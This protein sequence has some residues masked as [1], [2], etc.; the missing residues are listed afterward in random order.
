MITSTLTFD[1]AQFFP[2]LNHCLLSA[3]LGKAGFD[4]KVVSFF[5]NYLVDREMS[6]FWNNFSF[7]LYNVNVGVGQGSA[8]SSIL[9]ALY[10]SSFFHTLEKRLK[11]LDLKISIL[12]FVNDSLLIL[13]SKSFYTSNSHLFSSYNV[14]SQ[15]LLKFGLLVEHSKTEVF[16]F[17]RSHNNFNPPPLDLSSI[18]GPSLVPKDTWQY[19]EFIFDRKLSFCQHIDFYANKA[20]STV[21][22]M[23]ILGNSTRGLNLLQKQLLYRSC[24]L[25]IALYSFQL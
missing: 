15:L 19:L 25:P 11:T 10:L 20:I 1:I 13:Q 14:A 21:K 5:S 3:I 12:F 6:Y 9:S 4:L 24:A 22:C 8:L 23:K 16:H 7:C 2:S 17:S 18:G